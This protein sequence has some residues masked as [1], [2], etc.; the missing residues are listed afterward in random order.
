MAQ[1]KLGPNR[2]YPSLPA[3]DGRPES[4]ATILTAIREALEIGER[5]TGS[6][7]DSFVRLRELED[8]GLVN[9]DENT[10]IV[11]TPDDDSDAS[12]SH[13]HDSLYLRLTGGTVTGS[14]KFANTG[15]PSLELESAQPEILFDETD[16]AADERHWLLRASAGSLRVQLAT[17][18]APGTSANQV[19]A[20]IR[21][22]TTPSHMA[23]QSGL[24]LR[25]EDS[26]G[27]SYGEFDH[28]GT[29]FNLALTGTTDFNLTGLTN[30]TVAGNIDL[31]GNVLLENTQDVAIKDSGG[32]SEVVLTVNVSDTCLI[33]TTALSARLRGADVRLTHS[34]NNDDVL[35]TV[36]YN[37]TGNTAGVQ[38]LKHDNV[39]YDAGFNVTPRY[40]NLNLTLAAEHCGSTIHSNNATNYTITLPLSSDTDFPDDGMA[41][42]INYG[43]GTMTVSCPVGVSLLWPNGASSGGANTNRT[44]GAGSV[45]TLY[46]RGTGT[47]YIWGSGIT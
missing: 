14:V 25:I 9:I 28:D 30:L 36:A 15:D 20:I 42:V 2:A 24:N 21:S 40:N 32:T 11:V 5:R 45:A 41:Q 37:A 4:H 35:Q 46:R 18:A 31:T 16:A 17:D 38:I 8:L 3:V 27:S 10:G 33:G 47:W 26:G 19:L 13:N 7:L 23:L 43:T 29:D 1:I 39:L 34:S 6:I 12:D 22:G 44:I